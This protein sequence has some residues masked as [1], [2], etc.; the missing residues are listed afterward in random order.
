MQTQH[1]QPSGLRAASISLTLSVV[2]LWILIPLIVIFAVLMLFTSIIFNDSGHVPQAVAP[3]VGGV[4]ALD[5]SLIALLIFSMR[6]RRHL[7]QRLPRARTAM[8]VLGAIYTLIAIGVLFFPFP[9]LLAIIPGTFGIW[10]LIYFLKDS[11][12]AAFEPQSLPES[13]PPAS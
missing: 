7:A 8:L 13:L 4:L 3:F 2:G 6:T 1:P 11:T 5:L 9:D 10:W 12:R